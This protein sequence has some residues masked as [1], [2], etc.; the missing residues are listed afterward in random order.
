MAIRQRQHC[1]EEG[2][3]EEEKEKQD[4]NLLEFDTRD[5][6]KLTDDEKSC[7]G[8]ISVHLMSADELSN[9]YHLYF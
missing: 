4:H 2:G 5:F 6:P 8:S 7:S 9:F 3:E 1:P